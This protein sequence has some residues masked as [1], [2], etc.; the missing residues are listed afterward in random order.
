MGQDL[1][2]LPFY[3]GWKGEKFANLFDIWLKVSPFI[4]NIRLIMGWPWNGYMRI[5]HDGVRRL[6]SW[7]YCLPQIWTH[8]HIIFWSKNGPK[9]TMHIPIYDEF[10]INPSI[11]YQPNFPLFHYRFQKKIRLP[12]RIASLFLANWKDS[13]K[14]DEGM[15]TSEIGLTN[16]SIWQTTKWNLGSAVHTSGAENVMYRLSYLAGSVNTRGDGAMVLEFSSGL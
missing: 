15:W 7:V 10:L 12:I 4:Y 6:C 16:Y 3:M 1:W 2:W 9:E 11:D 14:M 13:Q 5:L 8:L